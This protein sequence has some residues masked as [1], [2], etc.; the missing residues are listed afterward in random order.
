MK[1]WTWILLALGVGVILFLWSVRENF[2]DTATLKGPP[3]SDSDYPII[4]NLMSTTLV[5]KLRDKYSAE[6]SGQGKPDKNTLEGQR[7]IVDGT[8]SSLMG[9]FHITVYQPASVSLTAANVDT[10]LNTK[11]TS[12]FLLDNKEEIKKLLV[13]YFVNQTAGAQN[14]ALTAAQ[15]RSNERAANSGYADILAGLNQTS[16]SNTTAPPEPTCP[17]GLPLTNGMCGKADI[18]ATITCPQGS[19][20]FGS[21]QCVPPSSVTSHSEKIA[22]GFT[23]SASTNFYSKPPTIACPSGYKAKQI[24]NKRCEDSQKQRPTCSGGFTYD[25]PTGKCVKSGGQSGGQSGAQSQMTANNNPEIAGISNNMRKGNIWGPAWTGLGDNTGSGLGDADRIYPIL[26]G[27]KPSLSKMVEGGGI[28]PVSQAQSLVS[29]GV[30]PDPQ[31]TGSD[32]NSQFFGT[33]R[34]PAKDGGAG[35]AGGAGG[36]SRVPGDQDLFPNPYVE[37]TPSSGS[38]KT[39]PVPYLSDFSAFL[40]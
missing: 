1:K 11:A 22:L 30:L 27:P 37:F 12:G 29:S 2:Q 34:S 32:P 3:Y 19:I 16:T 24:D 15:I 18:D 17:D 13:A 36:G 20:L 5:E 23:Y 7:K 35:G 4:V 8:I 33:A 38:S 21:D 25:P 39:E 6:N 9:D 28:A 26:L 10:F 31:S 40:N 14:V